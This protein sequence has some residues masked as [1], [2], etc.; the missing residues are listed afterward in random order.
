MS[1]QST[2]G[3]READK[4]STGFDQNKHWITALRLGLGDS[5]KDSGLQTVSSCLPQVTA[6]PL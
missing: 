1:I 5:K 2:E 4:T 6:H 3:T